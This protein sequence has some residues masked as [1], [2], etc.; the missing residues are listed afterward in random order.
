MVECF[1]SSFF[2]G[3]R[4]VSLHLK[5]GL[6]LITVPLCSSTIRPLP[7]QSGQS[8]IFVLICLPKPTCKSE[9]HFLP[10]PSWHRHTPLFHTAHVHRIARSK[11]SSD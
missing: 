4:P 1:Y 6:E 8:F 7:L 5:Q 11:I 10:I 9:Q 2:F 3:I